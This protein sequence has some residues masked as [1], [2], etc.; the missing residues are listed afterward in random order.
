MPSLPLFLL[1]L[2]VLLLFIEIILLPGFGAAGVPGIILICVGIGIVWVESGWETASLYAGGT[3][4]I[5][6]PLAILGLWLAPRTRLG[7]TV[8][9]RTAQNSDEGFQAPP[10][11]LADLVGH[12]GQSV[13]PL[14]PAGV[15][16]I[17]GKRVD[18][19]TNGEFIQSETDVEVIAVE[20]R[21]V[22][23]RSR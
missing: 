6:I 16:L 8:I 9:L 7:R 13:S 10:Q 19:V 4:V 23:V 17:D 11:E 21:R 1:G 20:G 5:I 22:V 15:A 14:R 2:G 18:V 3:V 12:A